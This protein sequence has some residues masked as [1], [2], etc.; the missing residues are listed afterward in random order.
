M[1]LLLVQGLNSASPA[2]G[3]TDSL[4]GVR[5]DYRLSGSA[6]DVESRIWLAGGVVRTIDVPGAVRQG[7]RRALGRAHQ[8]WPAGGRRHVSGRGR[9]CRREPEGRGQHRAPPPLLP[10]VRCPH[11]NRGTVGDFGAPRNG[12]RV[13]TGFDVLARCGTPLA[14]AATGTDISA[15]TAPASTAI[16]R[17]PGAG[18]RGGSTGTRTWSIPSTIQNGDLVHVGQIV[19]YVGKTG[20]AWTVGYHL[21]F[22][23]HV[24]GRPVN[25]EPYLRAWDR[26]S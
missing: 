14:A 15:P 26:N 17:H 4:G 12:G 11:G 18:G 3:F 7:P 22:E 24:N 6:A 9:G 19:G 20:N 25:P 1:G 5:I 16:R 2:R 21:H 10:R 13:H 23:D 8:W